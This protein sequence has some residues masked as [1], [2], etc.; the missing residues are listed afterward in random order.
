MR[1][2]GKFDFIIFYF[3]LL[4]DSA[5]KGSIDMNK[6]PQ[7]SEVWYFFIMT[8]FIFR[9]WHGLYIIL[10]I[11]HSIILYYI[12][13]GTTRVCQRGSYEVV[14]TLFWVLGKALVDIVLSVAH[15]AAV[16]NDFNQGQPV[17]KWW[18][19]S[20]KVVMMSFTSSMKN[21]A[22]LALAHVFFR[23][24]TGLMFMPAG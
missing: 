13:V 18:C 9:Y 19:H 17:I 8:T 20:P 1:T 22:V 23:R 4:Y 3:I 12:L 21:F 14:M 16:N 24:D 7:C 2:W 6:P 5:A 11:L 15:L 10:Y